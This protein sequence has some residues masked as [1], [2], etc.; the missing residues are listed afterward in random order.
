MLLG[1]AYARSGD[2]ERGLA[3]LG[4]ASRGA[5]G[6]DP[7]IRSEIALGIAL[8]HYQRRDFAQAE[9]ALDDVDSGQRHRVRARARGP[10]LDRESA[11]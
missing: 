10:R 5:A 1:T 11:Q 4:E 2:V 3:I 8:A 7:S 6:T 9:R